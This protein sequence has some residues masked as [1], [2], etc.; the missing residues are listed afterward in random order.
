MS[1]TNTGPTAGPPSDEMLMA[2]ADG[3]ASPAEAAAVE[4]AVADD[5]AVAERLALFAET[6]AM[7]AEAMPLQ[8]VPDALRASVEAMVAA[9]AAPQAGAASPEMPGAA[10]D[11]DAPETPEGETVVPF[12]RRPAVRPARR[13]MVVALAA[14]VAGI[15]IAVGAFVAG[16]QT[17]GVM[18]GGP[19]AG[20]ARLAALP[21]AEGLSLPSGSAVAVGEEALLR[22]LASFRSGTGELCRE[23]EVEGER[24]VV[25]VACRRD[26]DWSVDFAVATP[27]AADP[28]GYVPASGLEALDAYLGTIA[29]EP[30][31]GAQ[32]EAEAL[33]DMR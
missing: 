15:A 23:F 20:V 14:T 19:S 28:G 7:A 10:N 1:E 21:L 8:P 12:R 2:Y 32:E 16:W 33:Q 31:L 26:G 3:E 25:A 13:P 27:P 30:P 5:P 18:P 6:R 29:A 17:G 9:G 4:A 22:P 24:P 11:V